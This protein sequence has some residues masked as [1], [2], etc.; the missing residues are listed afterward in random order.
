MKTTNFEVSKKLK[1]IGFNVETEYYWHD[2]NGKTELHHVAREGLGDYKSY[3]LETILDALK[4]T[5]KRIM[6]V[7]KSDIWGINFNYEFN[8]YSKENE[9]LADTAGRLLIKLFEA[10]IVNFNK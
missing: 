2:I 5:G 1:E 7:V 6:I 3:D 8:I 4:Q 10:G 9:S